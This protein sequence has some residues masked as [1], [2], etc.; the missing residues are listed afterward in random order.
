MWLLEVFWVISNDS[1]AD[2]L[3]G[4]E[5]IAML[6]LGVTWVVARALLC[7]CRFVPHVLSGYEHIA[8]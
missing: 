1:L 6:L 7:G 5:Q 4:C 3:C 8:M 2:V